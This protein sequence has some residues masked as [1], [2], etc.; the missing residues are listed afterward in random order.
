MTIVYLLRIDSMKI[1]CAYTGVCWMLSVVFFFAWNVASLSSGVCGRFLTIVWQL[2]MRTTLRE[3]IWWCTCVR[4]LVGHPFGSI[5]PLRDRTMPPLQASLA[6]PPYGRTVCRPLRRLGL[7]K[8]KQ[9]TNVCL[10]RRTPN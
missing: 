9:A 3:L 1:Y 10:R 5:V 2:I 4:H 7:R 8:H 6:S